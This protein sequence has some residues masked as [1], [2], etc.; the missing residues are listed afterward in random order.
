VEGGGGGRWRHGGA[1][2]VEGRRDC[3]ASPQDGGHRTP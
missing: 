3:R 1:G 2:R